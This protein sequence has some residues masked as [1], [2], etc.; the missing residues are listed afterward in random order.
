MRLTWI[1]AI[2]FGLSLL[3]VSAADAAS[4]SCEMKT[5][6]IGNIIGRGPTASDALEDAITKCFETRRQLFRAKYSKDVDF[7]TGETLILVCANTRCGT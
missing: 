1:F 2:L 6:D 5:N 7:D 3:W 4:H